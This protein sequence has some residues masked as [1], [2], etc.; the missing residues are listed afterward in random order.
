MKLMEYKGFYGA[1]EASVEDG[2][3]FGKLEFIDPL[4]N[5]EGETVQEIEAAFHE[6]V[7][8]YIKTCEE[9]NVEPQKPYRGTFNVRIG[10]NLHRA[11]A[12]AARQ[13]DINL[14]ELVKRAIERELSAQK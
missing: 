11:A 9:S 12:I 4:V 6:A 8:D 10:R 13:K 7:D 14:N 5:Y 1:V 3:L 2:C